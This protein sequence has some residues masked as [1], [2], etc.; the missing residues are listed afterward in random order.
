MS[1]EILLE[2]VEPTHPQYIEPFGGAKNFPL[3]P[4]MY[5]KNLKGDLRLVK[6]IILK[7]QKIRYVLEKPD[8]GE[9]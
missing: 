7:N 2:Y 6:Q 3:Y 9:D 8:L 5:I 4:G 1:K